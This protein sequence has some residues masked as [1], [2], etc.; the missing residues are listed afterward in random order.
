[1]ITP[2][3][4]TKKVEIKKLLYIHYVYWLRGTVNQNQDNILS[5]SGGTEYLTTINWGPGERWRVGT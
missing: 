2:V 3:K 4:T 1:M 5:I